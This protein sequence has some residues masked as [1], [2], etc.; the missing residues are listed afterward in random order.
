MAT[1]SAWSAT[2]ARGRTRF[3]RDRGRA[4]AATRASSSPALRRRL[5]FYRNFERALGDGARSEPSSSRSRDQDDRW[6][7]DKLETLCGELGDAQLVYS[8]ARIVDAGR[9]GA[10]G[11]VLERA[12]ATTTTTSP[13]L[14][15]ANSVTG[16]A[17]LFRRELLDDALPFP[18]G[19]S[20]TSTTTGSASSLSPL[21]DVAFVDRPLYDYVQ[22]GGAVLGHAAANRMTQAR[23][24][25]ARLGAAAARPRRGCWRLAY[26]VDACRL[27]QFATIL[28]CAAAARMAPAKRRA[29][30]RFMRA[31]RSLLPLGWLGGARGARLVGRPETLG[32]ELDAL[33]GFAWRRAVVA[34]ARDR[35]APRRLRLDA[36]PPRTS[37]SK[38]GGR[39]PEPPTLRVIHEKLAPLDLALRRRRAGAGQPAHPDDRPRPLLRWLH[40]QAEPCPPPGRPR[41]AR[42]AS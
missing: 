25:V 23:R 6:D 24:P 27:L 10:R 1:G 12:A 41:P 35:R 19:Q 26:F 30:A 28:S 15:I 38:P 13:S 7:P 39:G 31:D 17:S 4:A 32:A 40:R 36:R 2:T 16:A 9:R 18:P 22:H 14:L 11:H 37:R 34:T 3:A 20:T 8:D 33:L 21:G 42:A 29:L 5:G